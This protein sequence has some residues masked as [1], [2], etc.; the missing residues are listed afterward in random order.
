[1]MFKR[2]CKLDGHA[3]HEVLRSSLPPARVFGL[4]R[5]LHTVTGAIANWA[6]SLCHRR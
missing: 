4:D 3:L 5:H 2:Q 1:M 6:F